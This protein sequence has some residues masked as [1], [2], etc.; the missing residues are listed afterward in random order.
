MGVVIQ[1][2][3][4]GLSLGAVYALIG[5]SINIVVIT[6]GV[7]NF[8]QGDFAMVAVMCTLGAHTTLGMPI[9]IAVV[10]GLAAA[11][12]IA[13]AVDL[14]AVRPLSHRS[15]PSSYGWL[16]STLGV[17]IMLQN[18]GAIIFGTGSEAFPVLLPSTTFT[19]AG[20]QISAQ[21][22]GNIAIVAVLVGMLAAIV[23][24]TQ[25]GRILR[26][27]A[28]NRPLVGSFGVRTGLARAVV[29]MVS[30]VLVGVAGLLVAPQTFANPFI[31]T[32]LLL[33]GF[34]AIVLG[35]LGNIAGGLVGGLA[36]GLLN[37]VVARWAPPVWVPYVPFVALM[38]WITVRGAI[39]EGLLPSIRQRFSVRPVGPTGNP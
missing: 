10:A 35:G 28:D 27:M 22:V 32:S 38:T 31:G 33:S 25:T 2:C 17:S 3:V 23:S 8:A 37:A 20:A 16:V 11:A 4:G 18:L 6:T 26:A 7:V 15:G 5:L 36:L 14:V 39:G 30:G 29:V 34:V 13:A 12:V 9:V 24:R 19:V 1:V 21:Q